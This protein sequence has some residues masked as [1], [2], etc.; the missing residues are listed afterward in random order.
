MSERGALESRQKSYS[1]QIEKLQMHE[2]T[3]Q[4]FWSPKS[5]FI[6]L[7]KQQLIFVCNCAILKNITYAE[8]FWKQKLKN[9]LV[10]ARI[11][12]LQN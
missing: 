5:K 12:Y 7:I 11:Y 4:N 6:K 1:S 8:I 3:L 2:S 9:K 10:N